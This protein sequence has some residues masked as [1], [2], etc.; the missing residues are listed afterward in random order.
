MSDN[1]LTPALIEKLNGPTEDAICLPNAAYTDDTFLELE[2]RAMFDRGWQF[3]SIGALIPK[4]GDTLPVNVAGRSIL[5]TRDANGDVH[6]FHNV[7]RHRGLELVSEPQHGR[8]TL[9]CPYH[10]WTYALNGDLIKT[11]HFCGPDCNDS[12][13]L[14]RSQYGLSRIRCEMWHDL[15]FVNLSGDAG[16]LSDVVGPLDERWK[17]YDFSLLRYGGTAEFD[18]GTNW[19]LA[20]ENWV[21]SYHLP[22]THHTLNSISDMAVHYSMLEPT[23]V[24]QGSTN[25]DVDVARTP[26]L[27]LFPGLSEK[28]KAV[29]EYPHVT[30]TNVNLGIHPN[31]F[32]VFAM[33][34][35]SAER[36]LEY[37]H[38]YFVGD[39]AMTDAL[40]A[41]R[42]AAMDTWITTNHEDIGML[43]GMQRGRHSPGY[44]DGKFSPY[45]EVTTHQFQR[46]VANACVG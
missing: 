39:E 11:P 17:E 14:D 15:I 1:V 42:D 18:I 34:P 35:V 3:A 41:Q 46:R 2:R 31:F 30:L 16:S 44:R 25:Y 23:Y 12:P 19:K 8:P 37:F 32:F 22:W 13:S 45:H 43:E 7:C 33:Q 6:A 5:L 10:S 24:G 26:D 9:V 21:E 29:A 38:F 27:P 4:R 28:A 40:K 20:V 36:T